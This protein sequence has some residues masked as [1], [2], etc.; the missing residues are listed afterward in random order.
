FTGDRSGDFLFAGLFRAG[1]ASQPESRGREDGL[2]LKNAYILAAARCAPP[3]NRPTPEELAN[4]ASY[5]DRELA[6]L[7]PRVVLALGAIAWDAAL[8]SIARS[9]VSIPR[10]RPRFAHAAVLTLA[11]SPTLLG[12]YHVSQQNTQTGRL[13]PRMFDDVM[14]RIRSALAR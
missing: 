9:G 13:T 2:I 4:C 12:C 8:G 7:R 3:D 11:G 1:F 10:P 5:L 6:L 14:A